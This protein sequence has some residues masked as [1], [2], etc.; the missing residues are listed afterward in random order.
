MSPSTWDAVAVWGNDFLFVVKAGQPPSVSIDGRPD[1]P[2]E[3]VPATSYS[4]HLACLE[5]V[6]LTVTDG[7]SASTDTARVMSP[8]IS[9][10]ATILRKHPAAPF[11]KSGQWKAWCTR[12]PGRATA[13]TPTR[14]SMPLVRRL[15]MLWFDGESY[16][17]LT[18]LF[19]YRL[20]I[21]SDNLVRQGRIP[22][23]I[24]VLLSASTGGEPLPKQF[25]GQSQGGAM[26][27]LQYDTVSSLYGRHIPEEVLPDVAKAHR[28]RGDAYSRA[29]A[30]QSSGGVCAF[31][32][33]WFHSNEFSRVH[34]AIGSFTG[35][36]WNPDD[37]LEGGHILP[38]LVRREQKRNMRVWMSEGMNDIDVDR[39]DRRDLYVAG[40]WPLN[41]I[42]LANA[43]KVSRY[44]FHFRYGTTGHNSA[45]V[46]LDLPESLAWL[47][48]DYDPERT[49]QI[50]E[51]EPTEQAQPIFR[52]QIANRSA[53]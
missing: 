42:R 20:R 10:T 1:I 23:M 53:W 11:P 46:A 6:S 44:D 30:G 17:G 47:W 28:I 40:S 18:D 41:N 32:L 2:M 35:L 39:N 13:C 24:N 3:R 8:A 38:N 31:T 27:S 16:L 51:Q 37:H 19:N 43:L 5:P 49:E 4:V 22:P 25:A 33:A 15:V 45:Q 34:S 52:V 26:R 21:V 50:Y 29:A 36:Q 48:R 14:G 12:A 7:V 9:Q